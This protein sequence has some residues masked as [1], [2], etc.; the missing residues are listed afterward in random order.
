MCLSTR[1]CGIIFITKRNI[2]LLS[3]A[4]QNICISHAL[5]SMA[6]CVLWVFRTYGLYCSGIM[7]VCWDTEWCSWSRQCTT[8]WKVPGSIPDRVIG[9]LH[10]LD[11]CSCTVTLGLTQ[12]LTE[13]GNR[14]TSW[15][16]KGGWGI[17]LTTLLP[18]CA[19]SLELLEA[20]TSWSPWACAGLYRFLHLFLYDSLFFPGDYCKHCCLSTYLYILWD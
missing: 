19:N 11:P 1:L 3:F 6:S 8:S 12:P 18:S 13:M 10:W 20:S 5:S 17:R 14:G 4:F 2:N 15:G 7:T 9:L 16:A